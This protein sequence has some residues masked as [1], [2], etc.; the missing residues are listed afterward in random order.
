MG[1]PRGLVGK[2]SRFQSIPNMPEPVHLLGGP[3]GGSPQNGGLTPQGPV[4]A[5]LARGGQRGFND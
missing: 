2:P 4:D 1:G 5:H 3:G